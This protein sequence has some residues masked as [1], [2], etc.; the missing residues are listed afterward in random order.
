[1]KRELINLIATIGLVLLCGALVLGG[2]TAVLFIFPNL[3]FFGAKSVNERDTQIVYRDPVLSDA[4]ANGKFILDSTGTKIEV[5]MSKADSDEE[6]TIVVNESAT[7]IAFNSLNRT[8]IE[9]TQ[10]IYNKYL[11]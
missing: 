8:L 1:M 5:K 9:W 6:G 4:F 7:G 11:S 10:T 2:L 3:N